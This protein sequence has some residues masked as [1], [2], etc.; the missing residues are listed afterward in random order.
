M[1][2]IQEILKKL[3]R[4]FRSTDFELNA[5]GLS[6]SENY[7][8]THLNLFLETLKMYLNKEFFQRELKNNRVNRRFKQDENSDQ[9]RFKRSISQKLENDSDIR[10]PFQSNLNKH[11]QNDYSRR[12]ERPS[13]IWFDDFQSNRNDNQNFS[14][15]SKSHDSNSW[16][17]FNFRQR[18]TLWDRLEEEVCNYVY[19]HIILHFFIQSAHI[20]FLIILYI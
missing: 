19:N 4:D 18:N 6:K 11:I 7:V 13:E 20:I 14:Q 2:E 5:K 12:R 1:A 10:E 3:E 16:D 17:I 8:F 9:R 15:K